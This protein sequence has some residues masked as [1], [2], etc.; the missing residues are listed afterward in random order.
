MSS[1][2]LEH[3]EE[4]VMIV[5]NGSLATKF[6]R[7]SASSL[8][9]RAYFPWFRPWIL[10]L[11]SMVFIVFL[12][13]AI[14][15]RFN[16]PMKT[17][18]CATT[19]ATAALLK[20]QCLVQDMSQGVVASDQA[21]CSQKAVSII[22]QQQNGTAVDAAIFTALCLGLVNPASSG[23]G[24]G[25]F[26]LLHHTPH[27]TRYDD[28]LN[29][30]APPFYDRRSN[31]IPVLASARDRVTEV[32]DCR[33]RAPL[34]ANTTMYQNLPPNASVYGALAI[35]VL[36]ELQ[37]LYLAHYRF[38][39]MQ[40]SDIVMPLVHMADAGIP[41]GAY[42]AKQIHD[43]AAHHIKAQRDDPNYNRFHQFDSLRSLLT[44]D[45]DWGTPLQE[46]DLL[47]NVELART[48]ESIAH[49]GKQA[50]YAAPTAERLS[51]EVQAAGGVLQAEDFLSYRPTIHSPLIVQHVHGYTVVGVPPPS[52]GGAAILG[53]LRF[54]TNFTL[55]W[56]SSL[57][58]LSMHRLVEACKHVFALRMSLSDPDFN[59]DTVRAVVNDLLTGSYMEELRREHYRD[60]ATLSV[61]HYG[62]PKWALLKDSEIEVHTNVTDAKE[63]D[64]PFR[65]KIYQR[66][67]LR[68][69]QR[70]FGYLNDHGTSHFSVVDRHGNA[71]AVTTSVNT[72]FGSHVRSP[73]TG[74]LFSNTMDDFSKPGVP[75]HYGLKPSESNYIQPG[76]RPLSSMSPTMVFLEATRYGDTEASGE[77][78]G[79]DDWGKL[80]L[81]IG[82]SGGPKII[83]SV[84]QVL[85]RFLWA[86]QDLLGAVLYPRLHDQ[87]IYHGAAITATEQATLQLRTTKYNDV[88]SSWTIDVSNLTREALRMRHHDLLNIDFSG[89]VQAIA[90]DYENEML[91]PWY[92]GVSDPRKGGSPFGY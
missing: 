64:R 18:A 15:H 58:T 17:D 61:S 44:H 62:G 8:H 91:R 5:P 89:T 11:L 88:T 69:L 39:T 6:S 7:S 47:R 9:L 10:W 85:L 21:L 79:E 36:G 57:S 45:N 26:L 50:L 56:A 76:K 49:Q 42:L 19:A 55:P 24:G 13:I 78:N 48:L 52:S 38:G 87:L 86:G 65:S 3:D 40:W 84:L 31:G 4:E 1:I 22:L 14:D 63:G 25:A 43:A 28:D 54:L 92:S 66:R 59:A 77:S 23:L 30:A 82:A 20:E 68:K 35:P 80:V 71:V 32:I 29:A 67:R 72:N 16:E 34:A 73:S 83:T 37:C 75:N 46:G 74:I 2:E 81:I 70:S 60:N 51:A 41:V 12:T 33:E 53:A 27:P 90:I